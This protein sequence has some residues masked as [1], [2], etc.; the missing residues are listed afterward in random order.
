AGVRTITALGMGR[1]IGTLAAL[2]QAAPATP[3]SSWGGRVLSASR[4][5][6]ILRGTQGSWRSRRSSLGGESLLPPRRFYLDTTTLQNNAGLG[7][8]QGAKPTK[9]E[10]TRNDI[11]QTKKRL[12]PRPMSSN[13]GLPGHW[14]MKWPTS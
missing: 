3:G 2:E 8:T 6:G 11:G 5:K 14:P 9:C 12:T 1:P 10:R 7:Q 13:I 4:A